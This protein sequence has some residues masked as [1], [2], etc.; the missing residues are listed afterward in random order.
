MYTILIN[1]LS[2][3]KMCTLTYFSWLQSMARVIAFTV[4][5]NISRYSV[6][7]ACKRHRKMNHV[8][9][10]DGVCDIPST[11]VMSLNIAVYVQINPKYIL[12]KAYYKIRKNLHLL[13]SVCEFICM[14][15]IRIICGK[16][17]KWNTNEKKVDR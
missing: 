15:R 13:Q 4:I 2:K 17:S 5:L 8:I 1:K 12:T 16:M 11:I 14:F 7:N 6:W 3:I 9:N 10:F